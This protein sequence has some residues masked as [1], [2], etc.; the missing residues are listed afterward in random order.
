MKLHAKAGYAA[1]LGA[2]LCFAGGTAAL[3]AAGTANYAANFSAEQTAS[4]LAFK[5]AAAALEYQVQSIEALQRQAKATALSKLEL[6]VLSFTRLQNASYLAATQAVSGLDFMQA[7]IDRN[8][9]AFSTWHLLLL[10]AAGKLPC[11]AVNSDSPVI[12]GTSSAIAL[13][14]LTNEHGQR[15]RDVLLSAIKEKDDETPQYFFMHDA[16]HGTMAAVLLKGKQRAAL[17]LAKVESTP[18]LEPTLKAYL[19]TIAPSLQLDCNANPPADATP[20]AGSNCALLPPTPVAQPNF[21]LNQ[22]P[23]LAW[24]GVLISALLLAGALY[25]YLKHSLSEVQHAQ[26][27]QE[28]TLQKLQHALLALDFNAA[29]QLHAATAQSLPAPLTTTFKDKLAALN[30]KLQ[31]NLQQQ[32]KMHTAEAARTLQLA[33]LPTAGALPSSDFLDIAAQLQPSLHLQSALYDVLRLNEDSIA[34]LIGR[35]SGAGMPAMAA[36]ATAFLCLR[37]SLCSLQH[38]GQALQQ[39]LHLLHSRQGNEAELNFTA[40]I[41]NEKTGN[42]VLA[43]CGSSSALWVTNQQVSSLQSPPT[44]Q[45]ALPTQVKATLVPSDTLLIF[46]PEVSTIT[47]ASGQTFRSRLNAL[48]PIVCSKDSAQAVAQL[49][50]RLQEFAGAAAL[51]YDCTFC[52]I[53]Q[54]RIHF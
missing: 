46:T 11:A 22:I 32:K 3:Y 38:P 18:L 23:G 36:A 15:L 13:L 28:Q 34:F 33:M 29:L 43:T 37:Q 27:K 49:Q 50:Q 26:A 16:P 25:L 39:A 4:Q 12:Y 24:A 45:D 9:A 47:N 30:A 21:S 7:E 6:A 54:Q 44:A 10:Q 48:A 40:G 51:E 17:L 8:A 14:K 31:D 20:I 5:Q 19:Q 1:L 42:L 53:K 52:A 35:A 41:I 2:L